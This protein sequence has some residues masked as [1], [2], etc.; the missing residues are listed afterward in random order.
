MYR[1]GEKKDICISFVQTCPGGCNSAELCLMDTFA[2]PLIL[3]KLDWQPCKFKLKGK[4]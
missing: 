1:K 3:V 4:Y 2:E